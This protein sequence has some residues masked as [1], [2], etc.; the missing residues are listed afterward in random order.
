MFFT[1]D[2]WFRLS[3]LKH[4]EGETY[5]RLVGGA[6]RYFYN[7]SENMRDHGILFQQAERDK[8]RLRVEQCVPDEMWKR[9]DAQVHTDTVA[10]PVMMCR[11]CEDRTECDIRH[12]Y[13][14]VLSR[15]RM[16]I[17]FGRL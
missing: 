8:T 15:L 3:Y 14:S 16:L 10:E 17:Q 2:E 7:T 9:C 1:R 11:P 5:K 12:Y 13:S 6:W 4:L